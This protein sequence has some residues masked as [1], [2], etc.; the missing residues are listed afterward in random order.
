VIL[1]KRLDICSRHVNLRNDPVIMLAPAPSPANPV[2]HGRVA[3]VA[4]HDLKLSWPVPTDEHVVTG[5]E[6][7]PSHDRKCKVHLTVRC[8]CA[9]VNARSALVKKLKF[10]LLW[11]NDTLLVL[12]HFMQRNICFPHSSTNF[13]IFS[14]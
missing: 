5:T 14:C 7:G 10:A 2:R 13:L 4:A 11:G 9:S 1:N 12:H 8:R 6:F 3:D